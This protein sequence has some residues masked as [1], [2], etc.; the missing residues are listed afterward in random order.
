MLYNKLSHETFTSGP[1]NKIHNVKEENMSGEKKAKSGSCF[2]LSLS[3][4][5]PCPADS[6]QSEVDSVL[7]PCG[8]CWVGPGFSALSSYVYATFVVLAKS[9]PQSRLRSYRQC[10]GHKPPAQRAPLPTLPG[11]ACPRQ[12]PLEPGEIMTRQSDAATQVGDR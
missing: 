9:P 8:R 12:P 6:G 4:M 5:V 1:S 10:A 3:S 7:L 11:A 2:S